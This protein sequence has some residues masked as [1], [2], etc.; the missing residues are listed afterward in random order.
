MSP[1]TIA[2]PDARSR[3]GRTPLVAGVGLLL[4]ALVATG[5]WFWVNRGRAD[6]GVVAGDEQVMT[7][8]TAQGS[9]ALPDGREISLSADVGVETDGDTRA[10]RGGRLVEIEW[11]TDATQTLP[12]PAGVTVTAPPAVG[13]SVRAGGRVVDLGD[14]VANAAPSTRSE[15]ERRVLALPGDVDDLR[16]TMTYAGRSQ[17]VELFTGRRDAGAFR[18][19]YRQFALGSVDVAD[20]QRQ[21]TGGGLVWTSWVDAT[22]VRTPYLEGRGWAPAG[23]EWVVV[24]R[25]TLSLLGISGER[26]RDADYQQTP[27]RATGEVA[28]SGA[29]L[30]QPSG[31]SRLAAGQRGVDGGR[32][33]EMVL[34]APSGA[35]V[36]VHLTLRTELEPSGDGGPL[37]AATF[38]R[39]V[40]IPAVVDLA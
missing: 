37:R 22:W 34:D 21:Q 30:V 4:L 24:R 26:D 6:V 33:P 9:F 10:P 40:E 17:S 20:S 15:P 35:P 23:R 12:V 38:T 36:Q 39:A 28:A 25:P 1:A 32:F 18:G 31:P 29:R 7:E 16:V 8:R 5:G 14:D 2:G 27:G 3:R 11:R 13:L 19:L